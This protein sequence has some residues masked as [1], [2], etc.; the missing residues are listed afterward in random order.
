M[1][2]TAAMDFRPQVVKASQHHGDAL[3]E[4]FVKRD[5]EALGDLPLGPDEPI[6]LRLVQFPDEAIPTR[7]LLGVDAD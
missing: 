3:R 1:A 5:A 6:A 4:P 7:R 2:M